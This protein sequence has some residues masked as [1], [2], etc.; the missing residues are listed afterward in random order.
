MGDHHEHDSFHGQQASARWCFVCGVVNPVG[1]KIKFFNDGHQQVMARVTFGDEYQSYPGIVHGGLIATV[2]D[3]TIG[4]AL[5]ADDTPEPRFMFTAT[6]NLRYHHSVP[7]NQ[8]VTVRGRID[9]D[10]GRVAQASGEL[11][12]PDGTVAVEASSTLVSIPSE[13]IAEMK[14]QDI[15]WQVYP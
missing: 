6:L 4:R 9:K 12:L 14:D 13:Q 1:L 11:L 3:E 5:L 8:E 2:L 7:L 10:R 15:G